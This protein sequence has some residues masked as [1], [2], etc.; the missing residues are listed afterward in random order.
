MYDPTL[1]LAEQEK[2]GEGGLD[3]EQGDLSPSGEDLPT[4][5]RS[6]TSN[7][8]EAPM[9]ESS[10]EEDVE[11]GEGMTVDIGG[12]D[13]EEEYDVPD[14]N[15]W[16]GLS[17]AAEDDISDQDEQLNEYQQELE[18]EAAGLP[19]IVQGDS[20]ES[21]AI[22]ARKKRDLRQKREQEELDRQRMMMPNRKRKLFDKMQY[23]NRR[24]EAE[25]EKLKQKRRRIESQLKSQQN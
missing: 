6:I 12:S 21:K 10:D 9:N 11:V 22:E 3:A 13:N 15:E 8:I 4:T 23:G 14:S 18:A 24:R 19:V 20:L 5:D 16:H 17:D 1:S 25:A 7:G 2:E